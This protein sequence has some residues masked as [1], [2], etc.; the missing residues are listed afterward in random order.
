MNTDSDADLREQF[1][2]LQEHDSLSVPAFESVLVRTP[3]R[4]RNAWPRRAWAAGGLAAVAAVG[5]L[6]MIRPPAP[7]LD[8]A[9]V[10]L[11]PWPTQTDSLMASASD[12]AQGLAWSPSPTSG[13]GQPSFN[14]YQESR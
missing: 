3:T 12:P 4:K 9:A 11:P 14:R 10:A 8:T 7:E 13:L 6:L 2:D 5:L 1:R